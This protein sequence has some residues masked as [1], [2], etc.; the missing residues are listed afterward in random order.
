MLLKFSLFYLSSPNARHRFAAFSI[1]MT[2]IILSIVIVSRRRIIIRRRMRPDEVL[3]S[4]FL[5]GNV[6]FGKTYLLFLSSNHAL[7]GPSFCS[8]SLSSSSVSSLDGI[9]KVNKSEAARTRASPFAFAAS[10]P[11]APTCSRSW[12]SSSSDGSWSVEPR[13]LLGLLHLLYGRRRRHIRICCCSELK[14]N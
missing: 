11:K 13:Y 3:F 12:K 8:L 6:I 9:A 7:R 5:P 2:G 10:S 1:S 14:K 4:S